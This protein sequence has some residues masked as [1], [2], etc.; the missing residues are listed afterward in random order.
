[1]KKVNKSTRKKIFVS[2]G[3]GFIGSN[4]VKKLLDIGYYVTAYDNLSLGKIDFIENYLTNP[5][6]RFAKEDLLNIHALKENMADHDAVFHMAANS[7]ISYG[8]K[9]TDIDLK[10][11]ILATYN[12]LE[13]MRLNKIEKIVFASSSAIYGEPTKMPTPEDYGPLLPISFYGASKLACEG[14]I[15]AFV[16]NF[17]MQA[18]IYRFA[19]IIGKNGTHGVIYDFIKKL[20]ET[21]NRLEILGDGRQAKPYVYVED[22]VEGMLFA[23]EHSHDAVNYFNLTGSG[24][25]DVNRIAKIVVQEMGLKNVEFVYT[26]QSRGWKGDVPQVELD[27][28]RINKLGWRPK[29]SSDEAVEIAT[30]ILV[31]Q[32]ER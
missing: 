18:W 29:Y 27:A 24:T 14:Y 5:A 12:I 3:A 25:T 26:G 11:G 32:I 20:R 13:C 10:Q 31:R 17:G 19:N 1:M 22:C 21:P 8:M 16:H 2:G 28:I 7:D 6:F 4:L 9:F 30:R 15:T 23:Y